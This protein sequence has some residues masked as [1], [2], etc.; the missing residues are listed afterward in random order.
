MELS[1]ASAT[2][3]PS[4]IRPPPPAPPPPTPKEPVRVGGSIRPPQKI[5]DV[6]PVYPA[7]ALETRIHGIVILE[8]VIGE[9]GRVRSLRVLRS[10]PLLDQAATDAVRQWVFTPTLLNGQPVPVAMTVTVAFNLQ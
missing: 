1:S 9:D 5:R 2:T 7:V 6:R 8:A 4:V 10:I 3:S